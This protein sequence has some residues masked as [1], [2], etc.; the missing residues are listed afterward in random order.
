MFIPN[1][2]LSK[3]GIGLRKNE[4]SCTVIVYNA[5]CLKCMLKLLFICIYYVSSNVY[6]YF[7]DCLVKNYFVETFSE[8]KEVHEVHV[9]NA[10]LL[11][12]IST[13]AGNL[14][15][16]HGMSYSLP[17]VHVWRSPYSELARENKLNQILDSF[18]LQNL[19][20]TGSVIGRAYDF[21]VRFVQF[22]FI[23]IILCIHGLT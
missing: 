21:D 13:P 3:I 12:V 16:P 8:L 17:Q 6:Q 22:V 18:N 23:F 20:R 7:Y 4:F 11:V 9:N 2:L 10:R 14:P 19:L 15:L 5:Q 1:C